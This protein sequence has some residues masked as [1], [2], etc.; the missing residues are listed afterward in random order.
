MRRLILALLGLALLCAAAPAA[1]AETVQAATRAFAAGDFIAAARAG[2]AAGE[3]KALA[4]AARAWIAHC[5]TQGARDDVAAAA[6]RA[7]AAAR[8]ALAQDPASVDARLQL[9]LALGVIGRRASDAEAIRAGYAR[10]GRRLIEQALAADP[11]EPWAHALLGAWHLEVLR[12]G[13]RAGAVFYGARLQEGLAAFDRAVAAAPED[14]ALALLYA[15]ALL[16]LNSE[17]NAE[18]AAALL[19]AAAEAPAADAFAGEMR[20]EARHLAEVLA[21][22]GPRAAAARAAMR[23]D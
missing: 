11:E 7:E 5:L 23:F 12:R 19:A 3:P 17:A 21:A 6:R 13:G 10:E 20:E 22:Q 16:E 2:E 14:P 8:A 18:R 1:R 4:M 15:V 9:A